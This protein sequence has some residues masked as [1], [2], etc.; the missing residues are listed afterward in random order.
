MLW[1]S[2]RVVDAVAARQDDGHHEPASKE[3][4][5]GVSVYVRTWARSSRRGSL[6]RSSS[7]ASTMRLR[8]GKYASLDA[9]GQPRARTFGFSNGL[10][11][12]Y[13]CKMEGALSGRTLGGGAYRIGRL[14][15]EGAM[16]AVYEGVQEALGRTVAVKVL[17]ASQGQLR[18]DQFARFQR[19]AKTAASLGHANI[20]QITDFQWLPGEPP[21]LVMERLVGQSLGA[22]MT[23]GGRLAP[24]RVSFVAAQVLSALHAAHEAGIVH[25][26]IKPDNVFLTL[27]AMVNDIVKVLDFGVAKLIDEAPL[28]MVG[29][30][31]GS[32]A[33][34]PP[35]QAFGRTVDGRTDVYA[36]GATMYHALSGVL[37]VDAKD[38]G[39]FLSKVEQPARPLV[40]IV[41]GF[42][43]ALSDVVA[44]AM[45]KRAEDRFP[46]ADAMRVALMPWARPRSS[47]I[48]D[49][50][51]QVPVRASSVRFSNAPPSSSR[52]GPV[53]PSSPSASPSAPGYVG[54]SQGG[55]SPSGY[56]G[57]S[58]GGH[59]GASQGGYAGSSQGGYAGAS[60]GGYAG[61][62]QWPG[63]PISPN[64]STHVGPTHGPTGAML[65]VPLPVGVGLQSPKPSSGRLPLLVGIGCVAVLVVL[66]AAGVVV[67]VVQRPDEPK[68]KSNATSV[69]SPTSPVVPSTTPEVSPSAPPSVSPPTTPASSTPTTARGK[70]A[71]AP[72]PPPASEVDAGPRSS[73]AAKAIACRLK[74]SNPPVFGTDPGVQSLNRSV[75][76]QCLVPGAFCTAPDTSVDRS[77]RVSLDPTNRTKLKSVTPLSSAYCKPF[78]DCLARTMTFA[79]FATATNPT[80]DLV[81]TITR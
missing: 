69:V 18:Q 6:A 16:G 23:R 3:L 4:P 27:M 30:M 70:D 63:A 7:G 32:P 67:F 39:E 49:L 8:F 19:E 37:P 29:A 79:P 44:T 42:D 54:A 38:A 2:A 20:V 56:A 15:G 55:A 22:A 35:E 81:C 64:A 11:L 53:S 9:E 5:V 46:S 36:V 77:Y 72:I 33:Y 47:S 34:M 78:D 74:P 26:D 17:H 40:E 51:A 45:A 31:I 61:S 62:S 25:R 12:V 24:Q 65:A 59:A 21:F 50:S 66:G 58:Q 14:L 75:S 13:H 28:T 52:L 43:P 60:Q 1:E 10:G 76:Q 80:F 41:P 73:N 71:G 57:A 68:P 48:G